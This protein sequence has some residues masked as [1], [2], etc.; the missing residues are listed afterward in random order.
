MIDLKLTT[1]VTETQWPVSR[2][3]EA[4]STYVV[5]VAVAQGYQDYP[6]LRWKVFLRQPT[7]VAYAKARAMYILI[8]ISGEFLIPF[9]LIL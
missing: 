8:I 3:G 7:S 4:D 9:S 6:G 5:A 2:N 1:Q